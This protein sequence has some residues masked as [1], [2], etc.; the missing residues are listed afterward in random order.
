MDMLVVVTAL[1]ANFTSK[2][3]PPSEKPY[4]TPAQNARP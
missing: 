3:S 4:A 1:L 2:R